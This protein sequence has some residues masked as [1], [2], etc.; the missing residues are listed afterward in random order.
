VPR[1]K[2]LCIQIPLIDAVLVYESKSFPVKA[3]VDSGAADN[4]GNRE[5][6]AIKLALDEWRHWLE[7]AQFPFTV[8]TD[9]KNLQYLRGAKRLNPRQARWSLLFTRFNFHISYRPGTK[10]TKADALSRVH[11]PDP[12]LEEPEPI[13]PQSVFLAPI[14]WSWDDQIQEATLHEPAPPGGPEGKQ[15]IPSSLRHY[16][17]DSIHTSPGSGHPGSKRTLSLLRNHYWWPQMARDVHRYIRGC[18]I[19]AINNTPRRLPE[20]KLVPLSIPQR[21]W[22]HIG[23]DF[24]TD[25][26]ASDGFTTILVVVDRFSKA[27]KLIPLPGLP[28]AMNTAQLLFSQIFRHF[29]IPEDIVSDRGPQF[30]SRVWKEFFR[31]LGVSISLSSGY[32]PQT[33]GQT[34]RKIQEIGR[35]LRSYCHSH[36]ES[37]NQYLP[38]AEYAQN[39]LRQE[40]TGLTPFQCVLGYQPP[41]FPWNDEPSSVPAV[42]Y[43]FRESERVWNSAHVHLQR[44]VRRHKRWADTRRSPTPEYQPG[45]LVWLSTRDINLRL[46]CRKLSPKFIGPFPVV[47]RLNEVTYELQLPPHYRIAPSFH[48]SLLK[49]H[50][51]PMFPPPADHQEPPP[52]P[53]IE[54]TETIYRVQEILDSRRRNGRL[55]YLIDW[56]GY[57]PE[58]RSWS[59]TNLIL[60]VQ[61]QEVEAALAV[62]YERQE[63]L[64]EE[65]VMSHR[66][67]HLIREQPLP[68]SRNHLHL[69]Q[70]R[71]HARNHRITNTWSQSAAPFKRDAQPFIRWL[72]S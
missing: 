70:H 71:S 19:C 57:G 28:T 21:P 4:V 46:P 11:Q 65:G 67:T 24:A 9:H 26:P 41:L 60:T 3:L 17:L 15:Y 20:G 40:T 2:N 62:G 61:P 47:R 63:T 38:W 1:P 13:L 53:E 30:T 39:S 43:W 35:Y 5:L 33:N 69:N 44:A 31:L 25:L 18:S 36:Q 66:H 16:I 6:L 56:E 49:R 34:E 27:C 59:S 12:S 55:Q 23:I 52:P 14:K 10:N 68:K 54:T 58:E 7:G 32:H 51:D 8:I 37:W 72:S 64:V 48:V 45:E 22:S 42:D 50:V 29:G